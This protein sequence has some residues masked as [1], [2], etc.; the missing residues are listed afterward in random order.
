MTAAGRGC[1]ILNTVEVP[2][3]LLVRPRPLSGEGTL[4]YLVRVAAANG[5]GTPRQLCAALMAAGKKSPYESLLERIGVT[6]IAEAHLFGP[7]PIRWGT[8]ANPGGLSPSDFNR[9]QIRWCPMCLLESAHLRGEWFLKLC[10]VCTRHGIMLCDMCPRC[11]QSQRLE[12]EDVDRCNCGTKLNSAPQVPAPVCVV[13]IT[14]A[15]IGAAMSDG[16]VGDFPQLRVD[17]W[18]RLVRHLGPAAEQKWSTRPGQIPG[19]HLLPVA[20]AMMRSTAQLLDDWP[21]NFEV[22]LASIHRREVISCSIPRTFGRLYGVL[23]G[24]LHGTD[25]Q[26]LRDAFEDYLFRNWWGIVCK[27]NH[28]LKAST[29]ASHPRIT[30]RHLAA[31]AG[32]SPST[33]R[34]L[35]ETNVID[36]TVVALPSGR[37]AT[38][39][40]RDQTARVTAIA[41]ESVPLAVASRLLALPEGRVREL[42]KDGVIVPS[43]SR[44]RV[45]AASWSIPVNQ[46]QQ[47]SPVPN[48]GADGAPTISLRTMVRYWHLRQGEFVALIRAVMDQALVPVGNPS[49]TLK[50]GDQ[51]MKVADLRS[52]LITQRVSADE[53]MSVDQAARLLGIKQQVAYDLV[54]CGLL[55]TR[56]GGRSGRRVTPAHLSEFRKTYISLRELARA[57]K[58]SPR[59]ALGQIHAKPVCGPSVDGAR[60]YFFRRS[61]FPC[62]SWNA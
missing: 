17:D 14:S 62:S 1:P 33:V 57:R 44:F 37:M 53:S 26:F 39:F 55:A 45:N 11:G 59:S 12:R 21:A 19:L 16:S 50:F 49:V 2:W 5:Y 4:G 56:E 35:F 43:I 46:I 32:T 15:V 34:H 23:Y 47:L 61:D 8:R 27:R 42:I 31:Q 54:G 38:A 22:L 7:I 48:D 25:F 28:R 58:Q 9:I 6:R 30:A 52:W 3:R 18:H 13:R 36:G 40:H 29:V 51:H 60:Q 24:D 10:C 20:A 41:H